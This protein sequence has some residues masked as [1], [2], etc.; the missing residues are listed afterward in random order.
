MEFG[1]T[2]SPPRRSAGGTSN[3]PSK[4]A[5]GGLHLNLLRPPLSR[6]GVQE[7][8]LRRQVLEKAAPEAVEAD[9]A[10]TLAHLP[11]RDRTLEEEQQVAL[12]AAGARPGLLGWAL[13]L[14]ARLD[15]HEAA[16][17]A[18]LPG[19]ILGGVLPH[20]LRGGQRHLPLAKRVVDHLRRV[21]IGLPNLVG[22]KVSCS[23]ALCNGSCRPVSIRQRALY[24]P[25]IVRAKPSVEVKSHGALTYVCTRL[26]A[27]RT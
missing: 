14:E 9:C 16:K 8:L 18:Q 12:A 26:Q 21:A 23:L 19:Q 15:G 3:R 5:R 25:G 20:L 4:A 11:R 1:R 2:R 24:V 17:H 7:G 22:R 10:A 13:E 6:S 27:A